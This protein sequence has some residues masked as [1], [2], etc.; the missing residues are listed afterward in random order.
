MIRI[1]KLR[2]A[3]GSFRLRDVSLEI[4]DGQYGVLI[5]P[6]GSGKTLL[7]ECVA[8]LRA[9]DGGEIFLG[10]RPVTQVPPEA[11][12]V[13][14]V[15]Q[16]WA[17]FPFMPVVDNITIGFKFKR[18]PPGEARETFERLTAM[19]NLGPLLG[20]MPA[21]LSGGERQRV[22]LA[23]ALAVNPDVLLLDEPFAS[24]DSG[25]RGQLG[26]EMNA[27]HRRLKKTCLHITHDLEEAFSLGEI[28]VVI[29]DGKIE[30]AGAREDV[31]YRPRNRAVASFLGLRNIFTGTVTA[32]DPGAGK[33]TVRC[34]AYDLIVPVS[35]SLREGR[36]ICFCIPPQEIKIIREQ[37]P[38]RD[39]LLDNLFPGK[40][41]G[42]ISHGL[43][44]TI[45][46]R[47]SPPG[48]SGGDHDFEIRVPTY[49]FQKLDL[50]EGKTIR[51]SLRR[52]AFTVFDG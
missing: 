27:L 24:L 38:I 30:Q 35:E 18:T 11:R 13:G 17:L 26:A 48:D 10:G 9:V 22:A 19:L 1:E 3:A 52:K 45:Y 16:D 28:V 29:I 34:G 6:T 40:I 7:M 47:I 14:Y 23:R 46:F 25:T 49:T 4:G 21:H 15:P 41:S 39:E 2:L 8:G 44:H 5:G 33:A 12:G 20:R 51:V 43:T 42:V 50:H 31:F 36:D 37:R 32:L